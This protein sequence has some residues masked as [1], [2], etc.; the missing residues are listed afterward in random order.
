ELAVAARG[1]TGGSRGHSLLAQVTS[2]Q[3]ERKGQETV[4]TDLVPRIKML[5]Y[6][7]KQGR[8][9]YDKLRFI[10]YPNHG[11]KKPEPSEQV[12]NSPVESVTPENS[13]LVWGDR[14]QLL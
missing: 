13:P 12:S 7:R 6:A 4:N 8:A 14:W 9:K 3:G 2:L 1:R 10:T 11:E 5:E